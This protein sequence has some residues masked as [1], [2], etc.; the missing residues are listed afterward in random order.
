MPSVKERRL[1]AMLAALEGCRRVCVLTHFNPDPDS[2]SSAWGLQRIIAS[3]TKAKAE[4]VYGG[5]IGRAENQS[6]VRLLGIELLHFNLIDRADFDAYAL[7]DTQPG[8]GNNPLPEGVVPHVV[9]DHHP[10][11]P[12]SAAAA[13]QDLREG[14]GAAATMI[15]EYAVTA[16]IR[17]DSRLATALFYGIKSETHNLGR[18]V[19]RADVDA[20]VELLPKVRKEV[21]SYIEHAPLTTAYFVMLDRAIKGTTIHGPLVLSILGNVENPDMVSECADL[22]LRLEHVNHAMAMGRFNGDLCLSF[23]TN[24]P[25]VEAG[26]VLKA[27]VGRDGNAGGHS[28]M[29]GGMVDGHRKGALGATRAACRELGQRL[30]KKLKIRDGADGAPLLK[31]PDT[32]P[33]QQVIRALL[34]NGTTDAKTG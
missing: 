19:T 34:R 27:V 4:V 6:M 1:K 33:S 18:G 3:R 17:L 5:I 31:S 8:T 10:D 23:R 26:Q 32:T 25:A 20:Y 21:V 11:Q 7:V 29:A 16:G 15:Y 30:I 2:I 14:V 9:I 28:E 24:D 22:M 13:Y 12:A